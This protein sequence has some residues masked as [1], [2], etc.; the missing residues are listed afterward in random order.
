MNLLKRLGCY[1][2]VYIFVLLLTTII[3]MY[4][5]IGISPYLPSVCKGLS[6]LSSN[7]INNDLWFAAVGAMLGTVIGVSISVI[8]AW[9]LSDWNQLL[10]KNNEKS[11][12]AAAMFLLLVPEINK[13]RELFNRFLDDIK[14]NQKDIEWSSKFCTQEWHSL[15]QTIVEL[16]E[17]NLLSA[18]AKLYGCFEFFNSVFECS[19]KV[20]E[21]DISNLRIAFDNFDYL[22]R[23][24]CYQ[25]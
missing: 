1:F 14:S 15:K 18:M 19:G 20:T 13:N 25:I 12:R 8:S 16:R 17:P 2:I 21:S 22:Y 3:S 11:K 24:N 7:L 4:A 10:A 9:V 23:D 6:S 5:M